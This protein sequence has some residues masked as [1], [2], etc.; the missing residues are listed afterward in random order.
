MYG[1]FMDDVLADILA[2]EERTKLNQINQLHP[3][4]KF[5]VDE[6]KKDDAKED[7]VGRIPFLDMELIKKTDGTVES[8]WYTK[9][10][11]T[12]T[13]MNWY[14]IAPLRYK[15]NLVMGFVNR[16]WSATTN[17][18]SFARG[19]ERAKVVL[20]QNQYPKDWIEWQFGRAIE[21][22]YLKRS[23]PRDSLDSVGKI[24]VPK[25]ENDTEN[26]VKKLVFLQYRGIETERLAESLLDIGCVMKPIF[27]L[28]KMKT[29]TPT[30]KPSTNLF[31]QSNLIYRYECAFCK[32]AYLGYTTR[33]L[34][35][36]AEEHTRTTSSIWKHHQQCE[37]IFDQNGFTCLYKTNKNR[38][39]LETV[40]AI[41]I[42]YKKSKLNDKDEFRSR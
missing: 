41:F 28:R 16:I 36:R 2:G 38:I 30:L 9:P 42:H 17:Y 11:D 7:E 40:E 13:I 12:G 1:K 35:V 31:N 23:H 3:N 37:G 8:E 14:A 25:A 4:L 29:M 20:I 27:T 6:M 19:C 32:E 33:H 15:T 21:K 24:I 22:V 34:G 39:F 10:T 5:T 18:E 26:W